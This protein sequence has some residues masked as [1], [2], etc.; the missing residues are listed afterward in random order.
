MRERKSKT[1][2]KFY[3]DIEPPEKKTINK[4]VAIDNIMKLLKTKIA[5]KT[6]RELLVEEQKKT[7]KEIYN[8]SV[9]ITELESDIEQAILKG[10]I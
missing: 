8:L 10:G 1:N 2:T 9:E 5:K 4:D 6:E 3:S 7:R